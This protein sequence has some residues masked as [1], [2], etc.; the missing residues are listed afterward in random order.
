[1][2]EEGEATSERKVTQTYPLNSRRLTTRSVERIVKA[3]GL[4][5]TAT[6]ADAR[7]IIEEKLIEQSREPRN[8]G[9]IVTETERGTTI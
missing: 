1:M 3:L 7:Q 9:V 4:P 5:T 8:V 2:A 6:L